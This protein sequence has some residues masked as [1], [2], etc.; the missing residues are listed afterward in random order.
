MTDPVPDTE[1]DPEKMS[2]RY[3]ALASQSAS[4][5][6]AAARRAEMAASSEEP[7]DAKS[8]RREAKEWCEQA[9]LDAMRAHGALAAE[10]GQFE[11][12]QGRADE[13]VRRAVVARDLAI[14]IYRQMKGSS[15]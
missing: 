14:S 15:D 7:R 9:T 4:K 12:K 11:A 6:E 3:A 2:S 10:S 8:A 1:V 13:A 5:A